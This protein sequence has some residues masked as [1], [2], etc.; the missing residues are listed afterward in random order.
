MK[1]ETPSGGNVC[2]TERVKDVVFS[3]PL[4]TGYRC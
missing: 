3:L 2:V 1:L 4:V